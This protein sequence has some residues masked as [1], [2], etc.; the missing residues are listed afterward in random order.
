MEQ[1]RDY[2]ISLYGL[3]H[4][5]GGLELFIGTNKYLFLIPPYK[6][7]EE[8]LLKSSLSSTYTIERYSVNGKP[9]AE[10]LMEDKLNDSNLSINDFERY[11]FDLKKEMDGIQI[12]DIYNDLAYFKVR[13]SFLGG[14]VEINKTGKM[15]H[16]KPFTILGKKYKKQV[17]EFYSNHNKVK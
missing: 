15:T 14:S 8:S 3:A 1:N 12:I 2:V 4:Q 5:D 17:K 10:Y 16:L 13:A 6:K 7:L 9:I 11:M